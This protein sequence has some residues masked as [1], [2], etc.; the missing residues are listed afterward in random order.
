MRFSNNF[1]CI[2]LWERSSEYDS[3]AFTSWTERIAAAVFVLP[4]L[5]TVLQASHQVRGARVITYFIVSI[6]SLFIP[7]I[8][9]D[10]N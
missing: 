8:D 5:Q 9:A 1:D 3:Y 2:V 7:C 10:C 6:L 4:T